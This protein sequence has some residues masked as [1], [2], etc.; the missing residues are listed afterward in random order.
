M[1]GA[2]RSIAASRRI[3]WIGATVLALTLAACVPAAPPPPP[4]P[5]PPTTTTTTT[6]TA[7]PKPAI[8]AVSSTYGGS[9][10]NQ[11]HSPSEGQG[12]PGLGTA[13]GQTSLATLAHGIVAVASRIDAYPPSVDRIAGD[14]LLGPFASER[15]MPDGSGD[16]VV[17]PAN[18]EGLIAAMP[19]PGDYCESPG[20]LL[21]RLDSNGHRES[22]SGNGLDA[23]V[24]DPAV[25]AVSDV[26]EDAVGGVFVLYRSAAGATPSRPD[27]CALALVGPGGDTYPWF[28]SV[29]TAALANLPYPPNVDTTCVDVW[30]DSDYPA[31]GQRALVVTG[32][33]V[34]RLL[35][36]GSL[37]STYGNGG[38]TVANESV[39]GIR[40][41]YRLPD[42]S[43]LLGS[44]FYDGSPG[45]R[46]SLSRLTP[47]GD[48]DPTFGTNGRAASGS[49]TCN[50]RSRHPTRTTIISSA[51]GSWATAASSPTARR[52][53]AWP[54][55]ASPRPA[56]PTRRC[57]RRP[58]RRRPTPRSG[59]RHRD[60]RRGRHRV[61]TRLARRRLLDQRAQP[62]HHHPY[63]HDAASLR[64][65]LR[66]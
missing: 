26:T 41:S 57:V 66:A 1:A 23:T 12:I 7:P 25:C 32:S 49:A 37:D 63:R 43:L 60:H 29:A 39:N 16:A 20:V 42:G 31:P 10:V 51:S 46:F 13:R 6:T 19:E 4:P 56:F 35:E 64:S 61:A 14:Y 59:D 2:L 3:R 38:T 47:D 55:P 58:A 8:G 36:D 44:T 30:T 9:G 11:I 53:P 5:A 52:R 34:V 21:R 15:W 28:N 50:L 40:S 48:L 45:Y 17:T 18:D 24:P 22:W 33:T 54:S 62:D 27:S 65:P